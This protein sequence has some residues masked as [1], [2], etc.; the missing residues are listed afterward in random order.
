[1]KNTVLLIEGEE[2][3]GRLLKQALVSD[4]IEVTW[5]TDGKMA[6][7]KVEKAKFDLIVM[8]LRLPG[9]PG[10]EVLAGIR[11]IDPYV[12]VIVYSDDQNPAIMKK[13]INL[14]VDGYLDKRGETDLWETVAE[15]KARLRP[16]SEEERDKLLDS[17]P[18]GI[19]DSQDLN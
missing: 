3:T 15:V 8:E 7:A 13:L 1:M 2:K 11:K 18:E 6:L 4:G 5:V 19:F 9:T 12:E 16:F 14:G 17:A 10:D